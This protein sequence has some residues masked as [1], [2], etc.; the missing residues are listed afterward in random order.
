MYGK[1]QWRRT[2]VATIA[3]AALISI[4]LSAPLVA[5]FIRDQTHLHASQPHPLPVSDK[6]QRSIIQLLLADKSR[7]FVQPVDERGKLLPMP[8]FGSF[9]LLASSVVIC[10]PNAQERTAKS[11]CSD[12]PSFFSITALEYDAEVPSKLRLELVAANS[13]AVRIPNPMMADVIYSSRT[14]LD[15]IL[16]DRG[17][18]AFRTIFPRAAG[19]VAYSRAVHSSD[20]Q[21]AL[22]YEERSCHGACFSGGDLHYLVR[23]GNTWRLIKS[24]GIWVS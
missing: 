12:R 13:K 19:Y 7:L 16:I 17:W 6:D 9:V 24:A 15:E 10:D 5:H 8:E 11:K 3:V 1:I 4:A 14:D 18:E 22:I 2:L 23:D 20:G 21:Y